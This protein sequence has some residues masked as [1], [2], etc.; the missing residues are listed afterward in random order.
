MKITQETNRCAV[1]QMKT[2]FSHT[3]APSERCVTHLAEVPELPIALQAGP[4]TGGEHYAK[5]LSLLLK[6]VH[7]KPKK[8][9]SNSIQ[10]NSN[11]VN[12]SWHVYMTTSTL[13]FFVSTVYLCSWA[14]SPL[15][16]N[17]ILGVKNLFHLDISG[18]VPGY[19]LRPC[20]L[21]ALPNERGDNSR[22]LS[23]HQ[24]FM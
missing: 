8:E 19:T 18:Q 1:K 2:S 21:C 15:A 24:Q 9:E 23:L 17:P 22:S 3:R 7:T 20:A 10:F 12:S 11:N 4:N 13:P 16:L 6:L 5:L 14:P